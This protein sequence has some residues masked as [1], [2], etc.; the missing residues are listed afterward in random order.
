MKALSIK[1]FIPAKDFSLS[2]KFYSQMGF[3]IDWE[4]EEICQFSQGEFQ[5]LLQNFY[6]KEFGENYML[7]LI[8]DSLTSAYEKLEPICK[9]KE[10]NP[11]RITK[12]A[13][14]PWGMNISFLHDPSNVLWHIGEID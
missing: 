14:Q 3:N 10:F 4:N 12:P 9:K 2:K 11:A 8:V 7:Q 1:P 5:F 6:I 13:I